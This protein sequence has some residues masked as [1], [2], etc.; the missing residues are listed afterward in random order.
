[1]Q[2]LKF[3]SAL[4]I[5]KCSTVQHPQA[6]HDCACSKNWVS[7]QSIPSK[8]ATL[9]LLNTDWLLSLHTMCLF[10]PLIGSIFSRRSITSR[11]GCFRRPAAVAMYLKCA[12]EHAF[13][14]YIDLRN[15]KDPVRPHLAGGPAKNLMLHGEI[16][17]AV[18]GSKS[19][20]WLKWPVN[21][22]GLATTVRIANHSGIDITAEFAY[23][24]ETRLPSVSL[25]YRVKHGSLLFPNENV[26]KGISRAIAST[27]IQDERGNKQRIDEFPLPCRELKSMAP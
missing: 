12:V 10:S 20:E 7:S 6:L 9:L 17:D 5:F 13:L 27:Q 24:L 23:S 15:S 3:C 18:R 26:P 1:M 8:F 19:S 22:L 25:R 21:E 11:A 14:L 4:T 2:W 16:L